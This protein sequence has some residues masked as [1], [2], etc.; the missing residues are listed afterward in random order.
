M[1]KTQRDHLLDSP[2][3]CVGIFGSCSRAATHEVED[4]DGIGDPIP[5]CDEH[6]KWAEKLAQTLRGDPVLAQRFEKELDRA[7]AEMAN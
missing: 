2:R 7:E 1:K 3:K 4:P 5:L 6:W